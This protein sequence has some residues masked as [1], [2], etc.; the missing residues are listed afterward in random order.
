VTSDRFATI[1]KPQRVYICNITRSKPC[2]I[3]IE[4]GGTKTQNGGKQKS[5]VSQKIIT[6]KQC[7]NINLKQK[8]ICTIITL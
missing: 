6:E 5:K 2:T 1:K 8:Q 4:C 3:S 7:L